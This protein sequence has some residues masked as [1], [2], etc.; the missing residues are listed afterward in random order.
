MK[1]NFW[2]GGTFG[3]SIRALTWPPPNPNPGSGP[4]TV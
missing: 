2:G 3:A 1:K 4:D